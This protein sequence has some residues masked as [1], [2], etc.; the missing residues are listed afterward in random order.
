MT[1]QPIGQRTSIFR[2]VILRRRRLHSSR[3]S[4]GTPYAIETKGKSGKKCIE[5][6]GCIAPGRR[7]AIGWR[8]VKA[9]V[10]CNVLDAVKIDAEGHT[11]ESSRCELLAVDSAAAGKVRPAFDLYSGGRSVT[12]TGGRASDLCAR[13]AM[14]EQDTPHRRQVARLR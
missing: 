3:I 2:L 14:R 6:N 4:P 9:C 7:R 13:H 11:D 1:N 12:Q 8:Q 10:L 5:S